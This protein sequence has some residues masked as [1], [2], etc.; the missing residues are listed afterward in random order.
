MIKLIC[1][2]CHFVGQFD[3]SGSSLEL[4]KLKICPTCGKTLSFLKEAKLDEEKEKLSQVN[5]SKLSTM[6]IQ[7]RKEKLK[8]RS[9]QHYEKH[10]KESKIYKDRA[11]F[12]NKD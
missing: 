6:S 2:E 7:D 8:E 12:K 9:N 11:F 4:A 3:W 10:I 1:R 5:I